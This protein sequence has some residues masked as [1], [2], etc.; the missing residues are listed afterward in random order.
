MLRVIF[1]LQ[2]ADV[3]VDNPSGRYGDKP[4]T[5]QPGGC[6]EPGETIMLTPGFLVNGTQSGQFGLPEKLFVVEWAR[7]RY[8][9]F[10]E[11]GSADDPRHPLFYV[12]ASSRIVPNGCFHGD[13]P[14]YQR[15]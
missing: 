4:R 12:S 1:Y 8:G 2:D 6:G 7:L 11:F 3:Q 14:M 10:E 15:E 9:V 5:V 13:D